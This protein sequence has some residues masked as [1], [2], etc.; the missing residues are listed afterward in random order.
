MPV[1]NNRDERVIAF[2]LVLV[3]VGEGEALARTVG[4]PTVDLV[5]FHSQIST[6]DCICALVC[7]K[8]PVKYQLFPEQL[9]EDE[10]SSLPHFA[11]FA[12]ELYD[13]AGP[14]AGGLASCPAR[15]RRCWASETKPAD[16]EF[17]SVWNPVLR[18]AA[19]SETALLAS[20]SLRRFEV[21]RRRAFNIRHR[22]A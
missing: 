20:R 4:Q 17:P 21:Y 11:I 8:P 10:V 15:R 6:A 1:W 7:T 3:R 14:G 19:S 22:T 2:L 13:M 18:D 12:R 16:D 9:A 5:Q